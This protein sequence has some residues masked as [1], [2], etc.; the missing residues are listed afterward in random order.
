MKKASVP[1]RLNKDMAWD[2]FRKRLKT[3][4]KSSLCHGDWKKLLKT[5]ID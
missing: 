4:K 1:R 3:V 2:M 5:T